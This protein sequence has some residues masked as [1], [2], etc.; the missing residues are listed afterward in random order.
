MSGSGNRLL[1][2]QVFAASAA[3]DGRAFLDAM[4]EDVVW[5]ITGGTA[6]SRSYRGKASVL[7]D[8]LVPLRAQQDGPNRLTASRFIA[9]DDL[10][11]VEAQGNATTKAGQPYNNRY[12][13]IFRIR[14]GKIV[15]IT[16]YMDTALVNEVL[17]APG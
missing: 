3:G 7:R 16:E 13:F 15:A 8:L 9:E 1:M 5:T 4:A 11:V 17:A 2:Q 10:V 6:W 14:D 12:C